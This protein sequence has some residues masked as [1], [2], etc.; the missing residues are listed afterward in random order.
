MASILNLVNSLWVLLLFFIELTILPSPFE[1][2][3]VSES[4]TWL[5]LIFGVVSFINS[6]IS[7]FRVKSA[8]YL[9]TILS[10]LLIL[11]LVIFEDVFVSV[12]ALIAVILSLMAI[13]ASLLTIRSQTKMPEQ[14][15]PLN[16]P[17]F[18]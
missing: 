15:H 11:I 4:L 17:V 7:F 3:K 9:A 8:F 1:V 14:S 5:L 18:G 16:L 10:L 12:G 13:S 6:L 2:I